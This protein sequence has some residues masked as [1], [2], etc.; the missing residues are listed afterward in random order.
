MRAAQAGAAA[1]A[2]TNAATTI[3]LERRRLEIENQHRREG[4]E[5]KDAQ[6]RNASQQFMGAALRIQE[7]EA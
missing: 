7:L 3:D 1:A 6:I 2:A 5:Q 4:G